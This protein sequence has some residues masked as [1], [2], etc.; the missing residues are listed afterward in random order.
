MILHHNAEY[1]QM[2]KK[3]KEPYETVTG[4]DPDHVWKPGM[5]IPWHAGLVETSFVNKNS[6]DIPDSYKC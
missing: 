5:V 3:W 6:A 1:A 2:D 4:F